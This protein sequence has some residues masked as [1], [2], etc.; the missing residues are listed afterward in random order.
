MSAKLSKT[1]KIRKML[2]DGESVKNIAKKIGSSANYVYYVKWH[3]KKKAGNGSKKPKAKTTGKLTKMKAKDVG[4]AVRS[5]SLAADL[6]AKRAKDDADF[7]KGTETGWRLYDQESTAKQPELPMFDN[8]NHPPH[9]TMGGIETIDFIEAKR[10]NYNR[11]NALKYLTRAGFKD[12]TTEIEDLKKAEWY[13][14]REIDRL[15]AN[16]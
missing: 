6:L 8:V 12:G 9:Y 16:V 2:A 7:V 14:T 4:K 5:L 3:D 1:E 11:G 10:L 13:L 15:K